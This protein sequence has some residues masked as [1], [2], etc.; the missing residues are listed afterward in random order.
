MRTSGGMKIS[1][2]TLLAHATNSNR[3]YEIEWLT[4]NN[5]LK[6]A[7]AC[8]EQFRGRKIFINSIP[9]HFL[10]D[11]DFS[12][13]SEMYGDLLP[14]LVVEFTEQAETEGEEL[15]MI[16]ERCQ[17]NRMDI[18]VDD[19]GTGYSNVTNLLKYSPNYVK[20]DRGLIANI[21]EEPKKQHFVTNIIEFAHANGFMALAAAYTQK[22]YLQSNA[23]SA[24]QF[25][26]MNVYTF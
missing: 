6:Y 14:Q 22:E 7:A 15:R 16:Q 2:L 5:V 8:R 18:A 12:R 21:H 9:G 20:I 3:L 19:Y 26:Y 10:N 13:L 25:D 24:A 4:Y 23:I 17:K 11:A 1:P